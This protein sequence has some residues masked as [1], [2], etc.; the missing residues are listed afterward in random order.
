MS[1]E[2]WEVPS[3]NTSWGPA[4]PA[5]SCSS[6]K[7][8]ISD[9]ISEVKQASGLSRRTMSPFDSRMPRLTARANPRF[10]PF[11]RQHSAGRPSY[12]SACAELF[13]TMIS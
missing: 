11:S 4:M 8:T 2:F 13:T 1:T 5:R 10:F 9:T 7:E 12:P 6:R 3:G